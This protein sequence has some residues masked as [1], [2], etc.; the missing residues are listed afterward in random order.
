MHPDKNPHPDAKAAFD[1]LQ[2]SFNTLA[3][4]QKRADYDK[5][6]QRT[7]RRKKFT[8]KRM[9]KF[10]KD[11]W[12]NWHSRYL[13]F[14]HHL[15]T[16]EAQVEID[17]FMATFTTK[18][19]ALHHLAQHFVLLPSALDRFKMMNEILWDH[20]RGILAASGLLLVIL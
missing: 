3:N 16:G 17:E 14:M 18:R 11:L 15:E 13:L 9:K 5:D 7:K 2:D 4:Y 12:F 10:W 8:V 19:D 20:K 1:A 6:L